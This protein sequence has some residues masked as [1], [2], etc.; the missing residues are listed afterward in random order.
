M[1]G[2]SSYDLDVSSDAMR[3]TE[4][5]P[6]PHPFRSRRDGRFNHSFEA[7]DHVEDTSCSLSCWRG[8]EPGSPE[9][10]E[11]GPGG[12]CDVLAR[13]AIGDGEPIPELDDRGDEVVCLVR[14]PLSAPRPVPPVR[15]Q[16]PLIPEEV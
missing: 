10:V 16:L 4:N 1:T 8:A 15:G 6:P 11:F 12:T 5:P 13:V 7:I 14:L 2:G 9:A 3:W